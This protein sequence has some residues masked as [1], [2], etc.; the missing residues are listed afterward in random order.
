[1][2]LQGFPVLVGHGGH[3][4]TG[5]V[6][7]ILALHGLPPATQLKTQLLCAAPRSLSKLNLTQMA[8]GQRVPDAAV[9]YRDESTSRSMSVAA[10][11]LWRGKKKKGKKKKPALPSSHA[12]KKLRWG[13]VCWG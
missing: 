3:S 13:A 8:A 7:P 12:A 6:G 2:F 10:K 11:A 4:T 1:M 9:I 5:L